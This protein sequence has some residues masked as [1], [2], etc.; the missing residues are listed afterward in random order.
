MQQ[1]RGKRESAL[2]TLVLYALGFFLFWEWLRPLTIVTPMSEIGIFVMFIAFLFLITYFRL[3][4]WISFP[5][6]FIAMMYAFHSLYYPDVFLSF[7]WVP[8]FLSDVKGNIAIILEQRWADTTEISRSFLFFI[9]LWLI[10]YLM[11]YWLIQAKKI[12]LF[13][14]ITVI[15]ITVLDTFTDYDATFA[16][17]RTVF[18]GLILIGILRMMKIIETEGFSLLK[19]RFPVLWM[20]PLTVIIS[21][22]SFFGVIAPK[23]SPQW[24]DPVPFLKKITHQKDDGQEGPQGKGGIARIGY[25]TN[26]SRLGGPFRYDFKPVFTAYVE[27]RHYWRVESKNSYTGKGWEVKGPNTPQTL[28]PLNV[29][30]SS[31]FSRLWEETSGAVH[32][33]RESVQIVMD[34]DKSYPFLLMPGML[35][36]KNY[37]FDKVSLKL[38]PLTGKINTF[39]DNKKVALASYSMSFLSPVYDENKLRKSKEEYP[40]FIRDNYLQLPESLPKRVKKLAENITKKAGN[41]YD[42][43]KAVERWFSDE[44]Y[45]YETTNV[46]VP[47]KNDDYV[48]QFLFK[49]KKGYCDNFSTSMAVLLRSVGI[50]TRWVKGFSPGE[51][52]GMIKRTNLREY[53]VTNANAHSWVEVYFTDA[54]WVPFEPTRGFTN[55]NQMK[56]ENQTRPTQE[57]MAPIKKKEKKTEDVTKKPLSEKDS[58]DSRKTDHFIKRGVLAFLLVLASGGLIAFLYRKQWLRYYFL[59]RFKRKNDEKTFYEAYHRLL[60]LLQYHGIQRDPAFTLREYAVF[61]D[62]ALDTK[63]MIILTKAYETIHYGNQNKQSHWNETHKQLWENLIKRIPA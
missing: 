48:D 9:L 63:D 19:G 36:G 22:S 1:A 29:N 51:F 18:I 41:P 7:R 47:G 61:V 26:D 53:K 42:K 8:H 4:F 34:K 31:P 2:H 58:S 11:H 60:W 17:I 20:A 59:W 57:T 14:F 6:K 52:K 32:L 3:P 24:P 54:G 38:D 37:N 15:Y 39:L 12:F 44:G 27:T 45:G 25:G 23:A 5:V 30:Y 49:T 56:E 40:G 62:R 13:F 16:I 55:I 33:K 21:L 35:I 28:N 46:A 43:A 50:P 10:S